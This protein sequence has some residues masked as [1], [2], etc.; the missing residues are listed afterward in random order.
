MRTRTSS[1]SGFWQGV[2]LLLL[3]GAIALVIRNGTLDGITQ[4]LLGMPQTNI[5]GAAATAPPAFSGAL[6]GAQD[7]AN[8]WHPPLV[9]PQATPAP[10]AHP[11]APPAQAA[12]APAAP[13]EAVPAGA[14][15]TEEY[16]TTIEQQQRTNDK[17]EFCAPRSG[18]TKP[19]SGG[20]LPGPVGAQP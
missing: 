15:M 1:T 17:G 4:R 14:P 7:A 18:C 6:R 10:L 20:A 11:A 5:G 19:G 13:A 3:M 12:P 16:K 2:V 8:D 9:D